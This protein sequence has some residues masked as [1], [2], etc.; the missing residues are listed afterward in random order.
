[1]DSR[2]L[3]DK[4]Q[5]SAQTLRLRRSLMAT[6]AGFASG[7][8]MLVAWNLGYVL[9][10]DVQLLAYLLIAFLGYLLFPWL[11]HS[12]RNLAY[13]DPSL[14][15]IQIGWHLL[16]GI[17]AM[18]AAPEIRSLLVINL[19]LIMLFAVFRLQPRQLPLV[20]LVLLASYAVSVMGQVLWSPV[21]VH[22][23]QESLIALV[24]SLAVVGISLLGAEIASL[25]LALKRR[26]AHLADAMVKIEELAVTDEL[27]GLYNR[28]H[29][30]RIL[31]RQKGL[32]DRG[33][34]QFAIGFVDLDYFKQVNDTYGHDVGDQMLVAV[35]Q[36]IKR[37]LR[38]VDYVARIGGEEFVMVLSQTDYQE[39]LRI[40][41]RLRADIEQL[42]VDIGEDHPTLTLTTS[43]GIA[44][45][46]SPEPITDLMKRADMALYTAKGCGRNCIVGEQELP[47]S[48]SMPESESLTLEGVE[49]SPG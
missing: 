25:R 36:E 17:Y 30:M 3:Q 1:M 10:S 41:E 27:T 42:L 24:F 5:K 40:A 6:G 2:F 22:W 38:D 19:L 26:N 44:A 47:D 4:S 48:I 35:A 31:R 8:V 45:Y 9:W 13:S 43:V 49:S 18:Y 15:F 20:A 14:T 11:I 46:H 23:P 12:S 37:S 28:R 34:Y 33:G 21:D 16:V 29:L 32:S 39:A 7:L